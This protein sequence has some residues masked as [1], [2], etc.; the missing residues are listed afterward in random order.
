M[1]PRKWVLVLAA[2]GL[3]IGAAATQKSKQKNLPKAPELLP[4]SQQ[5]AVREQWLV[6]RHAM[7]LDMMRRN[8]VDMWIVVNEEF[9]N[10]PLTEYIA[11]PR[12]Y[13]G[14]RDIFVFVDTGD[15]GL[16]KIAVTGYSE[17]NVQRFFESTDDPSQHPVD[18]QLKALWDTYHPAHI[19]LGIDGRRGVTRSLTKSTYDYLAEKM[20]PDA[21]KNFVPAQELIGEYLAT[22]IPEEFDTYNQEVI[23][24]DLITKRALSNEIITPGKTTVGD[25]RR[26]LYDEMWR[27]RVDTWFQPDLRVQRKGMPSETSRGFLAVA[28]E[29]TVI[30]PGDLVHLD[31]GISY[32]GM[33]TDWQ[34]MAYVLL[35]GEKTVPAGL[36]K[37]MDNTNALQDALM[38]RA[39]RPGRTGGEV[40]DLTM[41]E[42]KQKGI[43]AMIY[44]HP[45]GNQGHGLGASIDF[46]ASQTVNPTHEAVGPSSQERLRDGSYQSIEL[47]TKTAIPNGRPENLQSIELNTKRHPEWG[48][49]KI[50]VMAEDDAYLTPDGY[51][52]FQPRQTEFYVIQPK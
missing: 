29:E 44:S 27:S 18:K 34:K 10:D 42:M 11:P 2:C 35:P 5:I 7:L 23:L 41:A 1:N 8:H 31:F 33:S 16:K 46:R 47:N 9:H 52:F 40:Y 12:V 38:L 15:K 50:Y 22:R 14:G 19:G 3:L 28:K 13:T 24:T 30:E 39:A 51:K 4:W 20:G 17:E 37:A 36:Q 43:E 32:M 49:Q 45:I 25:V 21:A 48:G 6:K 26:W